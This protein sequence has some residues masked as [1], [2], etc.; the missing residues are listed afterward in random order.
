MREIFLGANKLKKGKKKT[1]E[2]F[3]L[4]TEIARRPP[5]FQTSEATFEI[6]HLIDLFD[7]RI[8]S[9]VMKYLSS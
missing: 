6:L 5:F 9:R 2:D 3:I 1:P 4:Y 8:S 7:F